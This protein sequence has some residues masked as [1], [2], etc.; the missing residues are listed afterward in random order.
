VARAGHSLQERAD[1][2]KTLSFSGQQTKASNATSF[3]SMSYL[4]QNLSRIH[5]MVPNGKSSFIPTDPTIIA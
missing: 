2:F 5:I 4:S 3:G 1:A